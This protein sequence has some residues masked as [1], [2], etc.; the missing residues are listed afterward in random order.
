[1]TALLPSLP[2]NIT[3]S[4]LM[5][6][7]QKIDKEGVPS[8][9]H[10]TT[11]DVFYNERY[12]PPKL[13]ISYAN[14][15]ANG[16]ALY[17]PDFRGGEGTQAFNLIRKHGFEI[18]R[19]AAKKNY[20]LIGT[21]Y[22]GKSKYSELLEKQVVSVGFGWDLDLSNYHLKGAK[23]IQ[24]FL[25]EKKVDSKGI[26]PLKKF[27]QLKPGDI[28][29]LKSGGRP[30]AG[31][32]SLNIVA[33]AMVVERGGNVY[34][35]DPNGLGHC[36]NVEFIE[37]DLTI[38]KKIGGYSQTIHLITQKDKL[39]LIFGENQVFEEASVRERIRIRRKRKG[40]AKR[41]KGKEYR[42]GNDP[43]VADLKHNAIQEDFC[44]Y[45]KSKFPKEYVTM[46]EDFVDVK[47]ENDKEIILYEVKPFAWAEDCIKEGLGQLLSY[48][49]PLLS[50]GNS[51]CVKIVV[52]GP[53]LP[54][55]EEL[56]F[57]EFVK[58]QLNLSFEYVN[59]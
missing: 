36:V 27:L 40:T 8:K 30:K 18:R 1:M 51:K 7:I 45:L 37:I 38:D 53:S 5:K 46:E 47:R 29:G 10:S 22:N 17:R 52:V 43:Y 26:N 33:Y 15:Y 42:S 25:K 14:I 13:I 21:S 16:H 55:K 12:Y 54:T 50:L 57:I 3:K 31:K 2:E 56:D 32:P 34:W 28:V 41:N 4:H 49:Y 59:Y 11:Y 24:S 20:Y 58:G 6:A 23:E 48:T 39:E 44:N 9:A 19:K 35:H